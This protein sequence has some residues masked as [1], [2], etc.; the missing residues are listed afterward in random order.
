LTS[1]FGEI[2]VRSAEQED[3]SIESVVLSQQ[4]VTVLI[5]SSPPKSTALSW[6]TLGGKPN[7]MQLPE[8]LSLDMRNGVINQIWLQAGRYVVA[9]ALPYDDYVCGPTT[10]CSGS[11][12]TDTLCCWGGN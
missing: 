10:Y 5:A 4:G 11:C 1:T 7:T 3:G 9:G 12:C 2:T 6:S 8:P